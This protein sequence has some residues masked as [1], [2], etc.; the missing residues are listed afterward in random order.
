MKISSHSIFY[1]QHYKPHGETWNVRDNAQMF[2]VLKNTDISSISG[3]SKASAA[4][5]HCVQHC[6]KC[7][8]LF[9]L[10]L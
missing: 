6:N 4:I 1:K 8:N 9:V 7:S 10:F 3:K 5:F 2:D